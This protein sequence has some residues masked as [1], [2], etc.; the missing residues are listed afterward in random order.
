MRESFHSTVLFCYF[1]GAI[2]AFALLLSSCDATVSHSQLASAMSTNQTAWKQQEI[3][4]DTSVDFKGVKFECR[5]PDVSNIEATKNP[6]LILEDK[7]DKPD[8]IRSQYISLNLRG[9]YADQ[10][11]ES[12]FKPKVEV[13]KIQEFRKVL[14]KSADYVKT[15]DN[16]INL[17]KEII[18]EQPSTLKKIPYIR[19]IDASAALITHVKCMQFKSGKGI[20]Y[21]T[22]FNI[23]NS[24]IN[25]DGLAYVF[26]GVSSDD[27]YYVVATFPLSTSFLPDSYRDTK[28]KD[29]EL[30]EFFYEPKTKVINER[31]YKLYLSQMRAELEQTPSQN[32]DPNLSLLEDSMSSLE[33]NPSLFTDEK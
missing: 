26:Q 20:F 18:S 33:I 22:Q 9:K 19:F 23:E 6:A 7:H 29:Y 4:K 27:E 2:C 21:V 17:L 15:F 3:T 16:K 13:Y 32:F 1:C 12:F 30:P 28:Y 5:I 10:H 24:L 11:A 8:S 31:N 14:A 25:N